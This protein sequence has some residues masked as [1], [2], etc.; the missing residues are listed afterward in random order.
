MNKGSR[1]DEDETPQDGVKA[2]VDV[3]QDIIDDAIDIES[4]KETKKTNK[5]RTKDTAV[6]V[7]EA[8]E[9]SLYK[10][11]SPNQPKKSSPAFNQ[12]RRTRSDIY[13]VC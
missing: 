9:K 4:S 11:Q 12:R 1:G 5:R 13:R 2:E 8:I 10:T 6:P 7:I 3:V